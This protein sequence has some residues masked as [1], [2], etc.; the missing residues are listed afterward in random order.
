[1]QYNFYQNSNVFFQACKKTLNFVLNVKE[2]EVAR[3]V[4]KNKNAE[5]LALPTCNKRTG[6]KTGHHW[7]REPA[8]ISNETS[9][10]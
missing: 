10:S 7:H 9:Q 4:R 5:R 8:I 2:F 6:I 1:M 3:A